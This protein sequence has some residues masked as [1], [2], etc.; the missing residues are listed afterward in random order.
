MLPTPP[1]KSNTA[2]PA[3]V[4]VKLAVGVSMLILL[5][6]FG[7]LFVLVIAPLLLADALTRRLTPCEVA[8]VSSWVP[9]K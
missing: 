8:A 9:S 3:Q 4:A 6:P 2:G 5:G 7:L 1:V